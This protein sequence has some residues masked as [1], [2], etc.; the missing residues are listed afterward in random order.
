MF[1]IE[2]A[3]IIIIKKH[4]FELITKKGE[5]FLKT[6]LLDFKLDVTFRIKRSGS[7]L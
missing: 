5:K 7:C 6:S 4:P 2:F 1:W 3:Q